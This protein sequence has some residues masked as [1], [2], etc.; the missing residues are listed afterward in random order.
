MKTI[1]LE[2]AMR[3]ALS[4]ALLVFAFAI[5]HELEGL[6]GGIVGGLLT[7]W[8][9]SAPLAGHETTPAAAGAGPSGRSNRRA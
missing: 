6:A 7:Y 8:L 2:L 9:P 5:R 4:L 3:G 1:Q